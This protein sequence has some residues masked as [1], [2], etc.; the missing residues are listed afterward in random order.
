M[1]KALDLF[2]GLVLEDGRRLG[3]AATDFQRAD[4][5]A[6]LDGDCPNHFLSRPRGAL[7]RRLISARMNI[8]VA[9]AQAPARARLYALA[10]DEKQGRLLVDS[11]AGFAERTPEL[12]GALTIHESRVVFPRAGVRLDVLAADQASH[13]GFAAVVCDGRRDLPV[14]HDGAP[15]TLFR[16]AS[17]RRQ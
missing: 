6:V 2:Y 16:G 10:A 15:A 7:R 11:I 9:L 1:S 17:R 3:E 13:L 5:A 4:A 12:R 14:A 8:A